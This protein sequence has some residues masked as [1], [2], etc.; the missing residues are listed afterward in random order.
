MDRNG[1]AGAFFLRSRARLGS[2]Y[3]PQVDA[4]KIYLRKTHS[5]LN[6]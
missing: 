3:Y 6:T 2:W 1:Q 4:P 5:Y